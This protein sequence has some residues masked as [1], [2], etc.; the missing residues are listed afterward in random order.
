LR[1]CNIWALEKFFATL[2]VVINTFLLGVTT[3]KFGFKHTLVIILTY[4]LFACGGGGSDTTAPPPPPPPLNTVPVAN[5]GVDQS[6][7][8]GS[9]VMLTGAA[10]TDANNDTLTYA[11]SF[12]SAP[13]LSTAA[14][15][16]V[17][18]VSPSFTADLEG[19]YVVQLIV[20]DGTINSVGN[21][22]T[23]SASTPNSAPV[24]NA[25]MDQNVSANTTVILDG[26]ESSDA[27]SD[28]LSYTWSLT[29]PASSSAVLS[30]STL[31]TPTFTTDVDGLYIAELTVNDGTVDSPVD[32]VNIVAATA[33]SAPTADAGANQNIVTGSVVTLDA[34]ASN[35]AN[36]DN[37]TYLWELVT[38]PTDSTANLNTATLASPSFTTDKDGIYV[39]ELTVNDGTVNSAV[40]SVEIV[41]ATANLAPTA[42]AGV[43]QNVE[44]NTLV[45]LDGGDSFDVNG[46]SFTYQWSFLSVPDTN[47]AVIADETTQTPSFTPNVEGI[48]IVQLLVN[49][50]LEVSTAD[51]VNITVTIGNSAPIAVA[52]A[53]QVLKTNVTAILNGQDSSDANGDTLSF[54]WNFVSRPTGSVAAFED[55][56]VVSPRFTTDVEGSYVISLVVFDGTDSSA[57]DTM[58]VIVT[59][60]DIVLSLKAG[61][62]G[63][64]FNEV[65]FPY[66]RSI[67]INKD[68]T[69]APD[70][71]T[72]ETFRLVAQGGNL[73]VI[74]LLAVNDTNDLEPFFT[75]LAEGLV[76]SDGVTIEFDVKIAST[77]GEAVQLTYS[78]E[79]AETGQIFS[80]SYLFTSN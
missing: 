4:G 67:T 29:V 7:D 31:P 36:G 56:T 16:D 49:D 75:N 79:I 23:I 39:A 1:Q 13:E 22:V 28:L 45:N 77:G 64:T 53:T 21:S 14:F 55:N 24:A 25:G 8:T 70:T 60:T 66:S 61:V 18:V 37:I 47:T 62:F 34:S 10:S 73:T 17:S 50:G 40:D 42:N 72:I 44:L 43:D 41:A 69:P 78:F 74:N 71:F 59:N 32:S 76:L 68:L 5:A 54:T 46:D 48:Y 51:T 30:G 52:G 6:V 33:N 19:S 9:E 12:T 38:V 11:W 15:S 35:D 26:S 63:D 3:M 27:D 65:P 80:S 2:V 58:Q 20:N 57:T